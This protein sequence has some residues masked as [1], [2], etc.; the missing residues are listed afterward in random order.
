MGTTTYDGATKGLYFFP[1]VLCS[2]FHPHCSKICDII[3]FAGCKGQM[4]IFL[5]IYMASLCMIRQ[6]AISSKLRWAW[7]SFWNLTCVHPTS[8]CAT[9]HIFF[10]WQNIVPDLSYTVRSPVL[11]TWEGIKQLKAALWALVST[12]LQHKR[13]KM[14]LKK[15]KLWGADHSAC[16]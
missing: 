6:A 15:W 1:L 16:I 13:E 9:F 7:I 4:S 3:W 10:F 12:V 8:F 14:C 2:D 11:D 5:C